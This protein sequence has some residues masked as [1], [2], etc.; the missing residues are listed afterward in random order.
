M[1]RST[2]YEEA[3]LRQQEL[4]KEAAR[5]RWVAQVRTEPRSSRRSEQTRL[6]SR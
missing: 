5:R 2:S 1:V 6:A 3:K 4:L